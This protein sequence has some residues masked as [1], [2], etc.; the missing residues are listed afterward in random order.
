MRFYGV[1]ASLLY[2][3]FFAGLPYLASVSCCCLNGE[4]GVRKGQSSGGTIT[5]PNQMNR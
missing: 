2:M 3:N 1:D 5:R 4:W